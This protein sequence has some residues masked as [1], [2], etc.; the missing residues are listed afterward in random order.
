MGHLKLADFNGA[1][2]FPS[3]VTKFDSKSYFGTSG[4][5]SPE[6]LVME[7]G[8][9]VCSPDWWSAGVCFWTMLH[10]KKSS[11]WLEKKKKIPYMGAR[12]AGHSGQKEAKY[13]V[14]RVQQRC[15]YDIETAPS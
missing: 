3:S 1:V 10:G 9:P 2:K 5:L 6:I 11:P 7:T 15:R 14:P 13:R 4:Y 12:A 8:F